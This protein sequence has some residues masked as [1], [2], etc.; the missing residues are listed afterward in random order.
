MI[1]KENIEKFINR[2]D[3]EVKEIVK[4]NNKKRFLYIT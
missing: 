4:K 2:S 1:L 3:D